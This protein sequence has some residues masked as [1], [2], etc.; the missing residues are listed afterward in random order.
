[1][2]LELDRRQRAMLRE[3]GVA[4]WMPAPA[5]PVASVAVRPAPNRPRAESGE[6]GEVLD[7][8][9]SPGGSSSDRTRAATPPVAASHPAALVPSRR[10][11]APTAMAGTGASGTEPALGGDTA[12]LRLGPWQ[13]LVGADAQNPE[14]AGDLP[15]WLLLVESSIDDLRIDDAGRLLA[16]MLRATGLGPGSARVVGAAVAPM[17]PHPAGNEGAAS[18]A[19]RQLDDV[20]A[21]QSPV[22]ILA[23]GRLA[24]QLVLGASEPMG[25]LRAGAHERAGVPVVPTYAPAYLLRVQQD[26]ARAW[27]DLCR[28]RVLASGAACP[29]VPHG[30]T[31]TP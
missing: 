4:V 23:M 17:D 27:D 11:P 15:L 10:A 30:P 7:V 9:A 2:A 24:A 18:G 19:Q 6:E 14:A 25:R 29:S 20:L 21:A 1:M 8:A 16:N 26:K 12:A 31:A 28:A 13:S 5:A 22:V 3:M